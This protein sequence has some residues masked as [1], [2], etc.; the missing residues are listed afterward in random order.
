MAIDKVPRPTVEID[1]VELSRALE[2]RLEAI[3]VDHSVHK[4]A[5]FALTFAEYRTDA[6]SEAHI[7]VGS[8]VKITADGWFDDGQGHLITGE[9]TS[10][11]ADFDSLMT[12][13]IVRGY[14]M[15]HRLHR[16]TRTET[17]R[18]VKDSD[19]AATLASRLGCSVGTIEDSGVTLDYVAQF[20]QSDWDFL[21]ARAREVAFEVTVDD[22][23]FNFR[24]PTEATNGPGSPEGQRPSP[25]QLV[26]GLD[27]IAFRPRMSAVGQS[28]D[29]KVR[30][31]D[32]ASKSLI[33][34][35]SPARAG[36]V[37]LPTSAGALSK[38]F[39]GATHVIVDRPVGTQDE[40]DRVAAAG[41]EQLGS[42]GFEAEGTALGNP[43]LRAGVVVNI[44]GLS[45]TFNGRY[46]LTHTRHCFEKTSYFTHIG[47]SGRRD[48]TL[49]GLGT[50][51]APSSR[52]S[53]SGPPIPGVVIGQ[54]TDNNDPDDMGRVKVKLPWLSDSYES[55]WCRMSQLGAGPD[56]GAVWVPEVNDEVLLAFEFGDLRRPHVIGSLYNGRDKPCLGNG[57]FDTGKVKRR[58]FVSR[59][60]HR[61]VF[62]DDSG[63]LGI[64]LISADGSCK[65][66]L[67]Q[68]D[69]E[70]RI[71]CQGKVTID[72]EQGEIALRSG[73]DLSVNAQ[74]NLK[75]TASSGID[76]ESDGSVTIKGSTI[77]LN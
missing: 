16:G 56:S 47:I 60:G 36:H 35:A 13:T 74:G 34:G 23:R 43:T 57:L 37:D 29:V 3:V 18:N 58:G 73:G 76:I 65:L 32:A 6:L 69:G 27:L 71:H 11:E 67:D 15:S 75:L 17:Y 40:A 46:T 8:T 42:C 54:V 2:G 52:P 61:L 50:V 39:P 10:I 20:N 21:S 30:A 77:R 5:M 7:R 64:A 1:D 70:I 45:D 22:G 4:P 26:F 49:L 25:T 51:A 62:L 66:A 9:V 48:R 68:T 38:P 55:D 41:A 19:I 24:R 44:S 72:T 28:G 14:D 12:K 31:W 53:A 33:L 63:Q 59:A